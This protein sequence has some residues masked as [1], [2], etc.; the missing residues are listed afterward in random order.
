MSTSSHG[1]GGLGNQGKPPADRDAIPELPPYDLP[2]TGWVPVERIGAAFQMTR[3]RMFANF[4]KYHICTRQFG[5]SQI[6][7]MEEFYEA[8]PRIERGELENAETEKPQ[9]VPKPKKRRRV[10]LPAQER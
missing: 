8:L 10:D 1:N 2:Q 6:V 3:K 7:R 5:D 9:P 4:A